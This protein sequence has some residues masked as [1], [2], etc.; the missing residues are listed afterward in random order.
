MKIPLKTRVAA[1]GTVP[2]GSVEGY[3]EKLIEVGLGIH[4][5]LEELNKNL[6][7]LTDHVATK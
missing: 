7:D 1:K 3:L 4:E 2:T 5:Q 6:S